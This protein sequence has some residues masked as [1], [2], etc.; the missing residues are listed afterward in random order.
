MCKLDREAAARADKLAPLP[1]WPTP[2]PEQKLERLR[3]V[4]ALLDRQKPRP[5]GWCLDC[6][7]DHGH[8]TC[9]RVKDKRAV[10][11]SPSSGTTA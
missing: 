2:T 6:E 11:P 7:M 5:K 9:F 3:T 10:N 4:T 8:E 1:A